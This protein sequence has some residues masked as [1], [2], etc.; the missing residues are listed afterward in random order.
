MNAII[1]FMPGLFLVFFRRWTPFWVGHIII[2]LLVNKAFILRL[3]FVIGAIAKVKRLFWQRRATIIFYIL[4]SFIIFH[5]AWVLKM[6]KC[7]IVALLPE[8]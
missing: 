4:L 1:A 2:E 8:R 5:K 3:L 7:R 6:D